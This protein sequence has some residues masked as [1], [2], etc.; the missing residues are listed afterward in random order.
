MTSEPI[1][2]SDPNRTP[3]RNR[4][5]QRGSG[6]IAQGGGNALGERAVQIDGDLSG[7]LVTGTQFVINYHAA[8]HAGLSKDEIARRV[9]DYLRWLRERTQHIELRGIERA[10]GAP[11]V[12]L[13]LETAYVPLRARLMPRTGEP[14]EP[15]PGK[16]RAS[17]SR[18][19][20]AI[21]EEHGK[22]DA[23]IALNQ[24][25]GLGNRLV[26][27]G[28][29]GCG[30]TTV[31]LHIA[32]ALATSLLGG[33]A[34]P[35]RSRLGLAVAPSAL[36]LPIFVP[37]ASFARHRRLNANA[38]ARDKTLAAFISHH[39]I[40]K[41]ADFGLPDDFFVQ[42][43]KDGRNVVLL[44]DG[45]DEVA[46]EG[47]RAA[48]RQCVEE[49]VSGRPAMRAIVTCRT[50]AYRNGR[51]AL[52]AEF[53]EITVQPLDAERHIAPMVRQAYGCIH[54][55]DAVLR[56]DR[57]DALLTGIAELE[58]DRRTRLGK[59][60][61]PLVDSPLMVRL[62]LIV[63]L[64]YRTLPNARADLFNKAIHALLQVDYGRDVEVSDELSTDWKPCLDMSQHLAFHMHKYG[65]DQGRVIDEAAL[66]AALLEDDDFKPRID[67]FLGDARQR[68]S[69]LEER[70]G[71]Y[72]F[73]HLAFQEFLVAR[74]L[75]DVVGDA[76]GQSA[77]LA[78]LNERLDDAW[79]REPILLLAG[80]KGTKTAKPARLFI[81][82][83]A[84]AGTTPNAR[85]CAAE[86]A[87][88]AALEW[89]DSGETLRSDCARRIVDLLADEEALTDA[90]PVSRARAG[91]ALSRL[92]DPRFDPQRF[93][94]PADESLGFVRIAAD[95]A[96]RIG[97][98]K[99]DARRV[100]EIIGAKVNDNEI[101]DAPTP[102]PEF[103]IG[104]YPVTVAQFR[105][106]VEATNFRLVN[107][108]ALHDPDSRPV[109]SVNWHEA[110]AYCEWLNEM[111][112]Y[113]PLLADRAIGLRV[114]E[115]G[116]RV[117]LPSELEWEKAARGGLADGVFPWDGAPDPQRANY[118][119]SGVGT[120][121]AVGC[122]PANGYG[123][124]DMLGNVW[125]W[126]R[127]VFGE[128]PY[129]MDDPQRENPDAGD[130]VSRVVRGGSWVNTAGNARCAFRY[131]FLPDDRDDD[132]GF[133][134]VLR[135][136][137][138]S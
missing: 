26:I 112:P 89:R 62:L 50:I 69:V 84:G 31:L 2:P 135:S 115:H 87:G 97:T 12:Y 113:T 104:R 73:M 45:L 32:W 54:P 123:L 29:P 11:V 137:P 119:D 41:Q 129:P 81:Q 109:Q 56:N 76:G 68:G 4:A 114:R 126:T 1:D 57:V 51:T 22:R 13:P 8:S 59:D 61:E 130:R 6:A 80:Y 127:S 39:L 63:Q 19:V 48:V 66:K 125:E 7:T 42:L 27:V 71:A 106:F 58:R 10:G 34:E 105:A 44:L 107:Q 85:F 21:D 92:G 77:I 47:E 131:W 95:P 78:M 46:N 96:F 90:K 18:A 74:Y 94:L 98:R 9:A 110:V 133:R 103:H 91:D 132:L 60:A 16:R 88:T 118:A 108:D 86:L 75:N 24:V 33:Q 23:D 40:D 25:L 101:N 17:S 20:A 136:A 14:G 122:F 43:F 55:H 53:R 49:L 30:K 121:S 37:L 5:R 35:A 28:G 3:A 99:A 64:S 124:H 36:P 15:A 116:W 102:T 117:A 82:S 83:L 67:K 100:A 120:T 138:V 134:V 52:G 128:Y 70:D 38:P 111:L 93:H 72:R 65:E 79:W